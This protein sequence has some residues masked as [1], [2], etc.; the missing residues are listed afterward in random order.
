MEREFWRQIALGVSTEDA[1]AA[2]G[3]SRGAGDRWFRDGGGMATLELS[4]PTGRYLSMAERE[5]IAVLRGRA[6][7]REIAR[8]LGRSLSVA[9][10]K[11][12]QVARCRSSLVAN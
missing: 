5:E 2:V 1:A 7:V 3:V 4:D 10:K 6:G 8:R 9:M 12:P 11:S